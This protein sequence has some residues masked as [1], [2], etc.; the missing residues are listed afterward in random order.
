MQ[1]FAIEAGPVAT[2]GYLVVDDSTSKCVIIDTPLVSADRF[3]SLI[4]ENGYILECILLT[5]SHWD[6]TGDCVKL[7][8]KTGVDIYLHKD[9]EYRL[10][11]PKSH[12][13]MQLPFEIDSYNAS[14]L[15]KDK[16]ILKIGNLEFEVLHT[17]GHTEGSVCFVEHKNKVV[18][19]GDTL[20]EGSIGRVDLPGG[21]EEAIFNSLQNVLMNLPDDYKVYC[22]HGSMTTIGKEKK[23]NPFLN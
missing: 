11:N 3:M 4:N 14:K 9:D 17:P 7:F 2:N 13:I 12:T 8:N 15:L 23:Y 19:S 21:D 5:H 1:I 18:F 20:F 6:H 22:G 10:R 16:D